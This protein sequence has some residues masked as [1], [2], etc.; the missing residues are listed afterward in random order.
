MRLLPAAFENAAWTVTGVIGLLTAGAFWFAARRQ[1][2]ETI[3]RLT[4]AGDRSPIAGASLLAALASFVVSIGA[5]AL[6]VVVW[7]ALS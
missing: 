1:S 3:R 5:V 6:A 4:T 7:A 2:T